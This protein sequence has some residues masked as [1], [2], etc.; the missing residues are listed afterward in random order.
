MKTKKIR[1]PEVIVCGYARSGSSLVTELAYMLTGLPKPEGMVSI[2]ENRLGYN[3]FQETYIIFHYYVKKIY[4]RDFWERRQYRTDIMWQEQAQALLNFL[5]RKKCFIFKENHLCSTI[6]GFEKQ[7]GHCKII[8]VDRD[9][10]SVYLSLCRGWN[11]S[12]EQYPFSAFISEYSQVLNLFTSSWAWP[13]SLK[14][15]YN[16]LINEKSV[17]IQKMADYL[18]VALTKEKYEQCMNYIKRI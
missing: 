11:L 16:M 6:S 7:F 15:N 14:I 10:S 4:K 18:G 12:S 1:Y 13:V 5:I 9:V 17:C 8:Y 2:H 3:E